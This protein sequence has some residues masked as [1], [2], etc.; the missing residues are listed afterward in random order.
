[1]EKQISRS[2]IQK[3]KIGEEVLTSQVQLTEDH[4]ILSALKSGLC[5]LNRRLDDSTSTHSFALEGNTDLIR[6]IIPLPTMNTAAGIPLFETKVNFKDQ[7]IKTQLFYG[8]RNKESSP[9]TIV[10]YLQKKFS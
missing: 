6:K 1:M 9:V 8:R 10:E 2:E 3:G 4:L 7:L 5:T